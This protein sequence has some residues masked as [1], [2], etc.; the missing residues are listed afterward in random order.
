MKL[1]LTLCIST[2]LILS[3]SSNKKTQEIIRLDLAHNLINEILSDTTD[4]YLGDKKYCL[5]EMTLLHPD[6]FLSES[7]IIEFYEDLFNED[8][9]VNIHQQLDFKREFLI[10][11]LKVK[12]MKILTKDFIINEN[13]TDT[14]WKYVYEDCSGG[15]IT[16]SKPIFS[17]DNSLVYIKLGYMCGRLCGAGESRLYRRENEKWVLVKSF[18]KWIS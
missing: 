18:S 7:E 9:T 11:S 14:F 13:F 6:C 10:D 15:Y 5:S 8:D 4:E 1:S 16:F 2:F 3:C 17:N 12:K